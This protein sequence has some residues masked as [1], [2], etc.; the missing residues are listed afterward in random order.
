MGTASVSVL[1]PGF[2]GGFEFMMTPFSDLIHWQAAVSLAALQTQSAVLAN[3]QGIP[4]FVPES[5]GLTEGD[6]VPCQVKTL[7]CE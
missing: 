2:L 6:T 4:Y 1:S 3:P 5:K 7:L